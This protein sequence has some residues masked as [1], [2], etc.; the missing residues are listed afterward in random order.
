MRAT[1]S[2][3]ASRSAGRARCAAARVATVS[4]PSMT[5]KT[6]STEA[7]ESEATEVPTCGTVT[8]SPSDCRSWRASRTGME[9]TSSRRARSS[10]TS[11]SPGGSSQRTMASRSVR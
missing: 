11:R 1:V 2:S 7:R 10:M 9:L 4:S 5:V 8:T 3:R 6:S